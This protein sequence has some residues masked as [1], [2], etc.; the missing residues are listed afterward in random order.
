MITPRGS[1]VRRIRSDE[2][3]VQTLPVTVAL[4]DTACAVC[5]HHIL[6]GA[7]CAQRCCI[8]GCMQLRRDN[9]HVPKGFH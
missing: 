3:W 4:S 8:D 6:N 7:T 9:I 2:M 1:E 5:Q